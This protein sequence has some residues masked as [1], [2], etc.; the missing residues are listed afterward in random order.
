[1]MGTKGAS[2]LDVDGG[3]RSAAATARNGIKKA[4]LFFRLFFNASRRFFI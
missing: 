1:M 4:I 2:P 3:K